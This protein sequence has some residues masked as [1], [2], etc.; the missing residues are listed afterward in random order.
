LKKYFKAPIYM[1]E[2]EVPIFCQYA[3]LA[4]STLV[5]IGA[6]LGAS[7][8]LMLVSAPESTIIYSIDSFTGDTEKKFDVNEG[9]CRGNVSR[10]L[11][12]LDMTGAFKRWHLY[13]Q[14]SHHAFQSW[15]K[16]IDFLYIDGDH[17]YEVVK[18]DFDDWFGYLKVGGTLLLHDSRRL[19]DAPDGKF[20]RGWPGPTLL[21]QELKSNKN[22]ELVQEAFSLTIWKKL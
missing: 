14:T 10:T 20:T 9:L 12:S 8:V 19:P 4:K 16:P 2:E 5:E 13:N 7:A 18:Q 3:S 6:G 22:I 15:S 11:D 1:H 17:R 21:A